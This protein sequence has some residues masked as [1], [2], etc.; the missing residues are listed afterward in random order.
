VFGALRRGLRL[1][2]RDALGLL[3]PVQLRL[4]EL[5]LGLLLAPLLREARRFLQSGVVFGAL[6][7]GLRLQIRDALGL[8][9]SI[10]LRLCE[11]PLGLLLAPLLRETRRLLQFDIVLA[12]EF[13]GQNR[14]FGLFLRSESV[15]GSPR[16]ASP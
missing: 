2:I 13:L 8:L 4:C 3:G 12:A 14:E 11:L 16:S 9:G 7:R 5:P 15:L 10:Q 1:Q 6:R